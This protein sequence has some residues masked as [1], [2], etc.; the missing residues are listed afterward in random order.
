MLSGARVKKVPS[1]GSFGEYSEEAAFQL[2]G[3]NPKIFISG[4]DSSADSSGGYAQTFSDPPE[5]VSKI[6]RLAVPVRS[7]SSRASHSTAKSTASRK[8]PS[9]SASSVGSPSSGRSR[10]A[11][12]LSVCQAAWR[13]SLAMLSSPLSDESCRPKAAGPGHSMG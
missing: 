7:G 4:D 3:S 6:A 12:S 1:A 5:L 11:K 13:V 10:T 2:T 9:P 8:S